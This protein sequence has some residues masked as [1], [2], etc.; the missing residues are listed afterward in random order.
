MTTDL[1][2]RV[3]RGGAGNFLSHREAQQP[4]VRPFALWVAGPAPRR[5]ETQQQ[6]GHDKTQQPPL[7]LTV[8]DSQDIEAQRPA[9]MPPIDP[10]SAT[11]QSGPVYR[12]AG[13]GG[14]GNFVGQ[15]SL[16][17]AHAHHQQ[18]K[19]E[20]ERARVAVG[21]SMSSKPKAGHTGR[22]G[23]G[24]WTEGAGASQTEGAEDERR[25][26]EALEAK[27][28]QDVEAGLKMPAPAY[29]QHDRAVE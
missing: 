27:I 13:R 6:D 24:N 28:L 18:E 14:A 1:F 19:D 21:A 20:A 9:N 15:A 8:P 4:E 29:H 22:G 10:A 5:T 16:T 17:E 23:M 7:S 26:V 11:G 2:R 25:R 12:P 3:G